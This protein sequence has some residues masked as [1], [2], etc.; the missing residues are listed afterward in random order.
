VETGR[1]ETE[2]CFGARTLDV[3]CIIMA[4]DSRFE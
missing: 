2:I 4:A 3:R 1:T